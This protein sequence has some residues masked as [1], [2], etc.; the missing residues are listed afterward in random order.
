MSSRTFDFSNDDLESQLA[1]LGTQLEWGPTPDLTS[2]VMATI[3][4]PAPLPQP[5]HRR[6][7]L[8]AA[9]MALLLVGALLAGSS[10]I[11]DSVAEFLGIDGL[12]IEFGEPETTPTSMPNLGTPTTQQDLARWLPFTPMQ[13]AA[14]GEPDAVYLR[15]LDNGDTLGIL[16]WEPGDSLPRTA[17]TNLGALLLQFAPPEDTGMML[18][19]VGLSTGTVTDTVVDGNRAFWVTG[20]SELTIFDGQSTESRPTGNV[21]IWQQDGIGFRLESALTMD[22]AIAIAESLEPATSPS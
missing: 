10:S 20:A 13:P 8:A 11:R 9:A 4:A 15:I 5:D 17:E 16:A 22:E 19:T 2:E 7:W 6:R 18:K 12:R 21:L 1:A 3:S 14:L